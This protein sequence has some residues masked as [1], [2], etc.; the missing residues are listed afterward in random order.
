MRLPSL[1]RTVSTQ[2][3]QTW[4]ARA[5]FATG[6]VC[7]GYVAFVVVDAKIFAWVQNRR[8]EQAM[9]QGRQRSSPAPSS[10]ATPERR[11]S[12]GAP[13][14]PS[15]PAAADTDHLDSFRP[16]V[17]RPEPD[18][19]TVLG[20]LE[21]PRVGISSLVLEGTEVSTL[22]HGAGHIPDTALPDEPG[23]VGIAAHRD[24]IFRGLKDIRKD[25]LIRL[26]TLDGTAEYRVDWTRIVEPNDVQVLDPTPG[27][28]ITLVTCYPF[29]Y[30][31]SAPHRFIVRGHR[32]DPAAPGGQT[33]APAGPG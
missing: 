12:S 18:E 14:S 31:G 30:V 28:E 25:D 11:W 21:I 13:G 2:A 33:A 29:Y 19:G 9:T 10:A 32:V 15:P 5:L 23:N 16:A 3:I 7:L 24:S 22:H 1:P 8:F 4:L 26:T 20:R 17:S 6:V 27:P